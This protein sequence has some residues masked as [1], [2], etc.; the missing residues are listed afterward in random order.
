MDNRWTDRQVDDIQ[1][2]KQ[3]DR[4]RKTFNSIIQPSPYQERQLPDELGWTIIS[5]FGNLR[6]KN[7]NLRPVFCLKTE[8]ILKS[9]HQEFYS[10]LSGSTFII[11]YSE[12]GN[13]VPKCH[14]VKN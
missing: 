13:I 4:C 7:V 3:E 11:S 9:G 1:V 2:R 14:Q 8:S 12:P 6:R 5:A 10:T